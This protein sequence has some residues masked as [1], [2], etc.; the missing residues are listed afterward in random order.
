[1]SLKSTSPFLLSHPILTFTM[2]EDHP[3]LLYYFQ[4]CLYLLF[5]CCVGETQKLLPLEW[6]DMFPRRCRCWS[7]LSLFYLRNTKLQMQPS[8]PSPTGGRHWN[9]PSLT[10]RWAGRDLT[11]GQGR[12]IFIKISFNLTISSLVQDYRYYEEIKQ[13]DDARAFFLNSKIY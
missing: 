6:P 3:L 10:G 9:S 2:S 13:W 1:M 8:Q 11:L 5:S 4:L 7:R 12:I